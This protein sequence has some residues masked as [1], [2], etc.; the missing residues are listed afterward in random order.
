V[1]DHQEKQTIDNAEC[2]PSFFL[3]DDLIKQGNAQ[4]IKENPTLLLKTHTVFALV[5]TILRRIPR[6]PDACHDNSVTTNS[7][8][9]NA[10]FL[11]DSGGYLGA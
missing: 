3:I 2:L 5:R 11:A 1:Y 8:L 10:E 6:K 7:P 4:S 9:D